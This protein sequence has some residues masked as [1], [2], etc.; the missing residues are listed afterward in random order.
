MGRQSRGVGWEGHLAERV[1]TILSGSVSCSGPQPER[2]GS[3]H[4][5]CDGRAACFHELSAGPVP[6]V[7]SRCRTAEH[8]SRDVCDGPTGSSNAAGAGSALTRSTVSLILPVQRP[9]PGR[10]PRSPGT[11]T[12]A[13]AAPCT[14]LRPPPRCVAAW[15]GSSFHTGL[16]SLLVTSEP[17][18]ALRA[19]KV[20]VTLHTRT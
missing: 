10:S 9:R 19:P 11:V 2:P 14:P 3:S 12:G 13:P 17:R 20:R 16:H 4:V 8:A 5:R 1:W 6:G 18:P 7:R 15:K